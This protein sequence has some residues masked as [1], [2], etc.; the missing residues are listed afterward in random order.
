MTPNEKR[1]E[2]CSERKM[3]KGIA[4]CYE[5]FNQPCNDVDDCPLGLTAES[6]V[7]AQTLTAEQ[8]K[9]EKKSTMLK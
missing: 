9:A 8:K 7:E 2:D 6:V 1:C 3:V 5:C 4:C